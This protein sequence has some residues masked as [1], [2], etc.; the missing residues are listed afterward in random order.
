MSAAGGTANAHAQT[1]TPAPLSDL[2]AA[3]C[4]EETPEADA[5]FA[6]WL[7]DWRAEH[8]DASKRYEAI[9]A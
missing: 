2:V 8:A 4:A 6:E 7:A 3:L 9:V 5:Q 1:S